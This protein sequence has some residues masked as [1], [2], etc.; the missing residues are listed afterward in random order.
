MKRKCIT[1]I[2]A[3]LMVLP[4]TVNTYGFDLRNDIHFGDSMEEIKKKETLEFKEETEIDNDGATVLET[5]R[6]EIDGLDCYVSYRFIDDKLVEMVYEYDVLGLTQMHI[7][8]Y[9]AFD[10][11]YKD[12]LSAFKE[13]Y[14]EPL[15]EGDDYYA[16]FLTRGVYHY[17]D[18][19]DSAKEDGYES[20]LKGYNDW[21]FNDKEERTIVNLIYYAQILSDDGSNLPSIYASFKKVS[22][23][24]FKAKDKELED[25]N[26]DL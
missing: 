23:E 7:D 22:D 17:F 4:S 6:A 14:G 3:M 13:R 12:A 19:D 11:Y 2:L 24:E 8:M 1:F 18:A 10:T 15:T 25:F 20:V 16:T 21:F 5:G 9:E 26:K